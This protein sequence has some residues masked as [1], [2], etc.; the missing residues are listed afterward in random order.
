MDLAGSYSFPAPPDS[1]WNLLIDPQVVAACLP[2]CDRLEPVGPDQYRA[3][4]TLT[5]AAVG[6]S[7]T[8]L[9]SILDKQPPRSY[10]LVVEGSGKPGFVKGEAI[11]ELTEHG[12][13]TMVNVKGQGQVGGLIARVG[14]RLLG[15]ASKM[16]M[17]RFFG[18][19]QGRI[20][21]GASA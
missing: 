8:V 19:L 16:M 11:V 15:S 17:D 20:G 14:Q 9:I 4:L 1:V 12:E 10:R 3:A 5:I 2:G 18:C 13:A 21:K 7:Y 6:G